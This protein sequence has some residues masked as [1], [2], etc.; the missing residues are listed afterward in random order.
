MVITGCQAGN[1]SYDA[2]EISGHACVYNLMNRCWFGRLQS[3]H[4]IQTPKFP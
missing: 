4:S 1:R 2:L 3:S